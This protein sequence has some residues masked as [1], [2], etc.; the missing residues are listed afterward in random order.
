MVTV[1]L[2]WIETQ[3]GAFRLVFCDAMVSTFRFGGN[4]RYFGLGTA[5][6]VQFSGSTRA[7]LIPVVCDIPVTYVTSLDTAS[8]YKLG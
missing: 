5:D 3:D 8:E 1:K 2:G 4:R 6:F 7:I